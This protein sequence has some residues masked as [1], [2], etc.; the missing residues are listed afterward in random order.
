M[1]LAGQSRRSA[2][3]R[4]GSMIRGV[5]RFIAAPAFARKLGGTR[6]RSGIRRG[7]ICTKLVQ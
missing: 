7:G 2:A 6:T 5:V 1:A 3:W 4:K